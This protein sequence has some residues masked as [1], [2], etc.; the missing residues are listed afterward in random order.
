MNVP[1]TEGIR[2]PATSLAALSISLLTGA[3]LPRLDAEQI[4][5]LLVETDLRGVLSHGTRQLAGYVRQFREGRLNPVPSPRVFGEGTA[6]VLVDGDG[7]L[8]HLAAYR[9]TELAIAR[10][11][12]DGVGTAVCRNHGHYGAAG[13]Y[14][15]MAA[16]RGCVGFSVSGHTMGGFRVDRPTWNPFGNPPMSFAFPSGEETPLVLDMGT[17]FFEPEHF[18]ALFGQAPA[19]FFKSAG[20]VAV[21]NL[22]AGVMAGMML[23]QFQPEGRRYPGAGYGAFVAVI[24]IGRFV[25]LETFVA[26]VDRSMREIHTLPALPGY[27]RYDLP[28]GLEWKREREWARDGIPLGREHREELEGIATEVGVPVPWPQGTDTGKRA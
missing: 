11:K 26:E 28:G 25:P 16:Q 18:P 10:A 7:G 19:A 17:S 3:G 9:A 1:P 15:R 24:D 27:D 20:L 21:A 5:S 8:G 4:T 23:P 2:V 12:A 13:K 6:T 14:T 22:L